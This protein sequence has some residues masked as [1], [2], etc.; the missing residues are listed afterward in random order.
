VNGRYLLV[1][2]FLALLAGAVTISKVVRDKEENIP[3]TSTFIGAA[4]AGVLVP[5]FIMAYWMLFDARIPA[6]SLA[7]IAMSACLCLFGAIAV[8]KNVR[9]LECAK[10]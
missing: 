1:I 7:T 2:A 9:D 6:A 10:K 8:S 4:W 5:F 3:V